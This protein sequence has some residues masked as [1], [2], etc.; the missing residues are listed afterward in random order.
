MKLKQ[1]SGYS[2]NLLSSF[3]FFAFSYSRSPSHLSTAVTQI[4]HVSW[5]TK[6]GKAETT[7]VTAKSR[8]ITVPT[9]IS[10]TASA[11]TTMSFY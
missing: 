4:S 10:A 2:S 5:L 1:V 11:A 3:P 8:K 6:A 7:D 9:F